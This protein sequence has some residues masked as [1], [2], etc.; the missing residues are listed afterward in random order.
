MNDCRCF[1][2]DVYLDTNI[3]ISFFQ[4]SDPFNKSAVA[5]LNQ[6]SIKFFTGLI[7]VLE[8]EAV[9]GRLWR[10]SQLSIEK[11]LEGMIT[12]LPV[13]YQ[14]KLIAEFCFMKVP[15]TIIPEMALES[16]D[17]NGEKFLVDN[18]FNLAY[19]IGSEFS[20]KTLDTMH[21]ASAMKI[22]NYTQVNLQYLVTND[23]ALL[24]E[25][26]EIHAHSNFLP[27]ST[28]EICTLYKISI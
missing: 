17:F 10:S 8:F 18:T 27:I 14:I 21:L 11:E 2:L 5:L 12:S 3:L 19:K 20:L 26:T 16:F 23:A 15:V 25:A 9:I 28:D 22:K 1:S 4:A 6:S 24:N 13:P 7:T